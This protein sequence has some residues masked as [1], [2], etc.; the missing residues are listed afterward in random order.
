MEQKK[1]KIKKKKNPQMIIKFSS[2]AY[3]LPT[4]QRLTHA[5]LLSCSSRV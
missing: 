2:L 4:L 5:A 1:Q 3:C